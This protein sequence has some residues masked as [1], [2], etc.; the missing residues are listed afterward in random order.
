MRV[1]G[2]RAP[3]GTI[4]FS[5]PLNPLG[6]PARLVEILEE[7]VKSRSYA[8]YPDHEYRELR[9]ALAE[10]YGLD[11]REV[12]PL[13]GAAE[14]LNLLVDL[15][16]PKVVITFEP[17]FGDHRAYL[18]ALGMP[19][20]TLPLRRY[21][22]EFRLEVE[23]LC[24]M[25]R[26][27]RE[28]SLVLLSN[29]NNPTGHLASREELEE[30]IECSHSLLVD[31]AFADFAEGESMLGRGAFVARSLTK[32]LTIPGLRAGFLYAPRVAKRVDAVRQPW[33]VN[34]LA[35]AAIARFFREGDMREF[36]KES[37]EALS[38]EREFLS[39]GLSSLRLQVFPSRAPFLL[40]EHTLPHPFLNSLLVK[41][42]VYV[43]DAS[44][45]HYLTPYHSRVSVRLRE[46]N[47]RLIEAMRL[48]M[49]EGL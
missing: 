44:S 45:F 7:L 32:V 8:R 23:L 40:M 49:S 17:T 21:R 26:E 20:I 10:Y 14:A 16:R 15:L 33:N 19:W 27:L 39:S 9:E 42:G 48:A 35:A 46:E 29:P 2:G 11:E 18:K 1:H 13:N 6:P 30:V 24:S 34:A 12:I 47:E 5:A 3:E 38:R 4:D 41:H 31:E 37:V 28:G 36:V 43:R 22:G 25:P